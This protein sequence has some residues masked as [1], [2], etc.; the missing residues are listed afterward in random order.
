[1]ISKERQRELIVELMN[2]EVDKYEPLSQEEF[3]D[4]REFIT[5]LG[6]YLPDNKAPYVW[7]MFNRLRNENEP[8][9][10]TCPSSAGHW[11]RAI[12]YLFDWVN[13]RK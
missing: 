5:T 13:K 2:M 9:P 4:L 10:C 1:M 6:P 8:Q 11:K 3:I 7:G 12:N